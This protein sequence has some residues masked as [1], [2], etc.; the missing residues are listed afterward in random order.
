MINDEF[1]L[2]FSSSCSELV[3]MFLQNT[4]TSRLIIT[5]KEKGAEILTSCL[6]H[7]TDMHTILRTET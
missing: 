1:L 6:I 5:Q 4:Q 3:D 7:E 2:V